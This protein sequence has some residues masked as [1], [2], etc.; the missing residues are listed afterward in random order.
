MVLLLPPPLPPLPLI[1][2][3][4]ACRYCGYISQGYFGYTYE[5]KDYRPEDYPCPLSATL[6]TNSKSNKSGEW[7]CQVRDWMLLV[8]LLLMLLIMLC[9]PDRER[10]T[11]LHVA[12][13]RDGRLQ[14][15]QRRHL[16]LQLE[17]GRWRGAWV[18]GSAPRVTEPRMSAYDVQASVRFLKKVDSKAQYYQNSVAASGHC[19]WPLSS[20][21]PHRITKRRRVRRYAAAQPP[22]IIENHP[23]VAVRLA[24]YPADRSFPA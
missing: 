12:Q 13:R 15:D 24:Q 2:L 10:P 8:M 11:G 7:F 23:T 14:A 21:R 5:K 17:V 4:R 16:R 19:L 20:T 3:V 9:H 6:G 1:L 18:E 22:L